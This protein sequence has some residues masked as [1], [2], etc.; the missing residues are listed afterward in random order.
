MIASRS[1]TQKR[2]SSSALARAKRYSTSLSTCGRDMSHALGVSK[3]L[4][5]RR[6]VT[7]EAGQ[8]PTRSLDINQSA[9]GP[10]DSAVAPTIA[11]DQ[12]SAPADQPRQELIWHF[13]RGPDQ[14]LAHIV[15][16]AALQAANKSEQINLS[17][18]LHYKDD[19]E[20]FRDAEDFL[21]SVTDEGLA[22][23]HAIL[24]KAYGDDLQIDW[25]LRW[26]GPLYHF[27]PDKNANA[28][29]KLTVTG[30]H[31]D[32]VARSTEAMS[33]AIKRG[34]RPTFPHYDGNEEGDRGGQILLS[35][36]LVMG[37]ALIPTSG[38]AS[39]LYLFEVAGDPI[40]YVLLGANL[41]FFVL[42]ML[43]AGWMYPSLEVWR[44]EQN[45]RTKVVR[46]VLPPIGALVLTGLGKYL[47]G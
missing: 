16:V 12:A 45:R 34:T 13:W 17:I 41:V 1:S 20:V 28:D 23:F 39:V 2:P 44:G 6:R 42:L 32:R 35:Y 5:G 29:I 27:G 15:R 11:D 33:A 14:L 47:F 19:L 46:R 31:V 40:A 24:V 26:T 4:S 9:D 3:G 18:E 38:L 7:S 37:I 10:T 22:H 43:G 30:T 36:F 25:S 8:A 21:R